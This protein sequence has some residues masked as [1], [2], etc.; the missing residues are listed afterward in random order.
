MTNFWKNAQTTYLLTYLQKEAMSGETRMYGNPI[1]LPFGVK[2]EK[3][4]R[5]PT[6]GT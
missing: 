1:V 3:K 6:L 2:F 5:N 4:P